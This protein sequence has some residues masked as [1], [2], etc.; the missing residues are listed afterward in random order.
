MI[1][2]SSDVY[3]CPRTLGKSHYSKSE[4]DLKAPFESRQS[5][6]NSVF[7][8]FLARLFE[9]SRNS[10]EPY[11]WNTVII[12][13]GMRALNSLYK[14]YVNRITRIYGQEGFLVRQISWLCNTH[15]CICETS[16]SIPVITFNARVGDET[17]SVPLSFTPVRNALLLSIYHTV[18]GKEL[19]F[20]LSSIHNT[21]LSIL[22][23]KWGTDF[24]EEYLTL[25]SR[26][27]GLIDALDR[28]KVD[29]DTNRIL[30]KASLEQIWNY[31]PDNVGEI[32]H[33]YQDN[34]EI[35]DFGIRNYY[36]DY[37]RRVSEISDEILSENEKQLLLLRWCV[38]TLCLSLDIYD[39]QMEGLDNSLQHYSFGNKSDV[40]DLF[41][42]CCISPLMDIMIPLASRTR[43][44]ETKE[45]APEEKISV[46]M[47]SGYH[48]HYKSLSSEQIRVINDAIAKVAKSLKRE[49]KP[50]KEV[51]AYYG[52][53]LHYG[54]L[55]R[56]SPKDIWTIYPKLRG[57][58]N[59][60]NYLGIRNNGGTGGVYRNVEDRSII[61]LFRDC[62][63]K[64]N[65]EL[66]A[67][68]LDE[69][70]I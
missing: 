27:F 30:V 47:T 39:E 66:K 18:L 46:V 41:F 17:V 43:L 25:Q 56:L 34:V 21:S 15:S 44:P 54:Y 16:D 5:Y 61:S 24:D 1:N 64:L 7:K 22:Y 9:Q 69:L 26:A 65:I 59:L 33:L 51:F 40:V 67:N 37:L 3:Y 2:A 36:K 38:S 20:E 58:G 14:N 48:L 52:A 63:I 10:I 60:T 8:S 45:V 68:G 53:L 23:N 4:L 35:E 42:L 70:T 32:Y 55:S 6:N 49:R 50:G 11:E 62:L 13:N 29:P 31:Y 12:N 19:N 28:A 57:D